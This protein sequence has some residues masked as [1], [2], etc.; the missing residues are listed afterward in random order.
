[1]YEK[2]K[3]ITAAVISLFFIAAIA[4]VFSFWKDIKGNLPLKEY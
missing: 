3:K 1:L 4:I 2:K